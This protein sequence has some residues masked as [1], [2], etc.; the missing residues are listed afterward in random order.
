M[1]ELYIPQPQ[2]NITPAMNLYK[3]MQE[4]KQYE[5]DLQKQGTLQD[6]HK[7]LGRQS[8]MQNIISLAKD[9][10]E[11]ATQLFNNDPELVQANNGQQVKFLNSEGD[12]NVFGSGK[13][14]S[15]INKKTGKIV[16]T[17][18]PMKAATEKESIPKYM[19]VQDAES[20][21]GWSYQDIKNPSSAPIGGAPPPRG[22]SDSQL[23]PDHKVIKDDKSPT[24]WSY[25]NLR[26]S[27]AK[28][29][30]GAPPPGT[31][32]GYNTVLGRDPEGNVIT[33][34]S[35][36][37]E[38]S[39]KDSDGEILP[40]TQKIVGEETLKEIGSMNSLLTG[41]KNIRASAKTQMNKIG[42]IEGQWN[43]LKNKFVSDGDFETM[44]R[45]VES[46]ITAAYA[47][48]GKQ[49]SVQE[50]KILK[51]AILPT[52]TKPDVNFVAALDHAENWIRRQKEERVNL[53]SDQGY[54]ISN[55]LKES[56]TKPVEQKQESGQKPSPK[57]AIEEL[58][59]RGILK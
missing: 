35:R 48:S 10:P 11:A 58:R 9:Q 14:I 23:T 17:D 19:T 53:L 1:P 40:K 46:L 25:K 21:T 37:A 12:W 15:K 44:N 50:L 45:E 51:N 52:V 8:K 54:F 20:S 5:L 39:K 27:T 30:T 49:I 47:L 2:D 26:N 42:P 7:Q 24:G 59:R 56:T 3:L 57:D 36:T 32:V 18:L 22:T 43:K 38:L 29:I 28:L 16:N 55:A 6:Y 31:T 4:K 33:F 41:I 13:K 34:N